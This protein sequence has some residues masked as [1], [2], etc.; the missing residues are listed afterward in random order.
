MLVK[1]ICRVPGCDH[2][3][4]SNCTNPGLWGNQGTLPADYYEQREDLQFGQEGDPRGEIW[5]KT[6]P[7]LPTFVAPPSFYADP[8]E[9]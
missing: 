6:P 4:D 2:D 1:K 9:G 3:P 5:K 8:E 7:P